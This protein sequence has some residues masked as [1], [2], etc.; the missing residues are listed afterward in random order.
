MPVRCKAQLLAVGVASHLTLGMVFTG[1]EILRDNWKPN[2]RE[3]RHDKTPEGAAWERI[4]KLI[5]LFFNWFNQSDFLLIVYHNLA[6]NWGANWTT[7]PTEALRLDPL[8]VLGIPGEGPFWGQFDEATYLIGTRSNLFLD[9]F[10]RAYIY[11]HSLYYSTY[12]Y[13]LFI[14]LVVGML[15]DWSGSNA[16]RSMCHRVQT[17]ILC[18][19][20]TRMRFAYL[21]RAKAK[22]RVGQFQYAMTSTDPFHKE[23]DLSPRSPVWLRKSSCFGS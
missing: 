23:V 3:K 11:I 8:N 6:D 9:S 14:L 22:L 21:T 13:R 12:S 15:P 18:M 19:M 5:W 10:I 4:K 7:A 16:R 1:K 2:H 20:S 17:D